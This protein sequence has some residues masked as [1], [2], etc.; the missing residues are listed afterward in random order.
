MGATESRPLDELAAAYA[1]GAPD[2][3]AGGDAS[4]PA[5]SSGGSRARRALD[6]DAGARDART[7]VRSPSQRAVAALV[8][9]LRVLSNSVL[10]YLARAGYYGTDADLASHRSRES[11]LASPASLHERVI[12]F[13]YESPGLDGGTPKRGD[14]RGDDA[15]RG[16]H[17][18]GYLAALLDAADRVD[19][20]YNAR[21]PDSVLLVNISPRPL[22]AAAAARSARAEAE[23]STSIASGSGH[24]RWAFCPW[25]PF[26]R[27]ARR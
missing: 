19:A 20:G 13:Q 15:R 27:R 25:T 18:A 21:C 14:E 6:Y 9:P 12:A 17:D 4:T 11:Y 3:A 23:S 1:R 22:P 7:P 8:S 24:A 2:G 16:T 10:G 5:G 26:W